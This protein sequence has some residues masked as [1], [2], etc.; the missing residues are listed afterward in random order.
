MESRKKNGIVTAFITDKGFHP[1]FSFGFYFGSIHSPEVIPWPFERTRNV[2]LFLSAPSFLSCA[3]ENVVNSF[4]RTDS[5]KLS[6]LEPW[7]FNIGHRKGVP[8]I[9][10]G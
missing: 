1:I 6:R 2:G 9:F 3:R 5:A 10:H 8:G 4:D 7:S